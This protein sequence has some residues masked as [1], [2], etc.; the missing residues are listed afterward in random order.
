MTTFVGKQ[1]SPGRQ[2]SNG[3][4]ARFGFIFQ[5]AYSKK[6]NFLLVTE[7]KNNRIRKVTMEGKRDLTQQFIKF[8]FYFYFRRCIPISR[9]RCHYKRRCNKCSIWNRNK[10]THW[11]CLCVWVPY[12]FDQKDLSWRY[13]IMQQTLFSLFSFNIFKDK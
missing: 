7:P 6:G 9:K 11:W 3:V 10:W 8:N 2:N 4:N 5:L 13:V 12:T 1:G